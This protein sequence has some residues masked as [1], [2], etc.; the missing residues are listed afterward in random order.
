LLNFFLS[1]ETI[2]H[3]IGFK[4]KYV[5]PF[6][7]L[8]LSPI[9]ILIIFNFLKFETIDVKVSPSLLAVSGVT[10]PSGFALF[11]LAGDFVC[12]PL[13]QFAFSLLL[14]SSVPV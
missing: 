7:G 4:K 8:W 11:L 6:S 9:L 2:N 10:L 12:S 13:C 5:L 1:I 3:I 14:S